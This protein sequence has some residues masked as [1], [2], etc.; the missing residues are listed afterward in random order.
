MKKVLAL[1]LA[2]V[3]IGSLSIPVFA[4]ENGFVPSITYKPNPE[5]VPVEDK[6]GGEAIGVICDENG[7][8]ID[9]VDHGCLQITPIAYVWDEEMEVPEDVERLLTFVY[10]ELDLF[11]IYN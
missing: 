8:I 10:E 9:Y 2:I 7:E 6:E 3:I 1:L 11:Y 5:I 4:A